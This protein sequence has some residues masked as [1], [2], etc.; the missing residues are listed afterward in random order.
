MSRIWRSAMATIDLEF[1]KS[2]DEVFV[3]TKKQVQT[4][5]PVLTG[6]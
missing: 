5:V 2:G 4:E 1:R 6:A 3:I